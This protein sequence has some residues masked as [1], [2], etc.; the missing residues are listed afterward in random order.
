MQNFWTPLFVLVTGAFAAILNNSSIN[1]AVPKLMTIYGVSTDKIQWVVTAYMLTSGVVIPVTGYLGDRFGNK[2]LFILALSLFTVGSVLCALSWSAEAMIAFRIV[3]AV[4]GGVMMPVSM[5]II[6]RIVPRHKIGTALGVWGMAAVAAPAIGPTLGGYII[7]HFNWHLLFLTNVPIG[8]MGI[9]LS[10]LILEETPINKNLKFDLPGFVLSTVGCFALLLALSEGTSEGWTSFKIVAL[11]IISLFTLTAFVIAEL[12]GSSPMLDLRML[13]NRTFSVSVITSG[14]ITIGLFG[15]VFLMPIFTQ[16]LMGLTPYETG[17]LLMPAAVASALMMPVSGFLFD[18]IGAKPLGLIGITVTA[19][20]TWQLHTITDQTSAGFIMWLMVVRA[21]GMG[22]SAMPITTAGMNVVPKHLVGQASSLNNVFRQIFASFGIAVLT[23]IMQ[24]R[25]TFHYARLAEGVSI[26]NQTALT[27]MQQL[28]SLFTLQGGSAEVSS[29]GAVSV[30][31]M[32]VQKEA[33]VLALN[34]T[35]LISA[36][37]IFAAVPMVF[38][39]G[40]HKKHS[41]A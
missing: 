22:L 38:L 18:K 7:D 8:V 9:L 28:K 20:C 2:R 41:A 30:L 3:Q 12:T 35:F 14:L 25:Q 29:G 23:A 11:F 15:G 24:N 39:L 33:L 37:F 17:L 26:T 40:K 4:G 27:V 19:V 16:N 10:A 6:Y 32:L 34:D 1:V 13:K 36:V 31:T 5:A 21:L